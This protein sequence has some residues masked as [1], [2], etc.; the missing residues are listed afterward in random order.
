MK[1]FTKIFFVV[2]L[3]CSFLNLHAQTFPYT[4]VNQ[5]DTYVDLT[6]ETLLTPVL[7]TWDDPDII[8]IPLGFDF[9]ILGRTHNTVDISYLFLGG[10]IT[11]GDLEIL[12]STSAIA[13]NFDDLI[14]IEVVDSTSKSTISYV[15]DGNAG[16]RI[17][18]IQWKN[19][20]YY[21]EYDDF[22]T[23]ENQISFQLWLYEGSNN[24]EFRFGPNNTDPLDNL[25]GYGEPVC[26]LMQNAFYNP[27]ADV[28]GFETL[29]HVTGSPTNPTIA[30][31][32]G[33]PATEYFE[34][35]LLG[36]S[37]EFPEGQVYRF[38]NVETSAP[39]LIQNSPI[40]VFPTVTENEFFV[41]IGEELLAEKTEILVLNNFGQAIYNNVITSSQERV[42]VNNFPKGIYYV[43]IVNEKGK[44]TQKIIK[45]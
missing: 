8:N 11:F 38:V 30:T 5:T 2:M 14:D 13:V 9:E 42:D 29:W 4:L 34:Y 17:F 45:Q 15:T 35:E 32:L 44:A 1:N 16:Q 27:T 43:S 23:T 18:K 19:A 25:H 22:G 39:L 31:V 37:G 26:G 12:D 20:G 40:K 28:V 7:T 6:G 10:V 33:D 21:F 24:I 36:L 3:T 41:E